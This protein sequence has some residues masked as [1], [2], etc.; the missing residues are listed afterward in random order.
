MTRPRVLI[1]SWR[2][3][4]KTAL[5][6]KTDLLTLSPN[7]TAAVSR[8]GGLPIMAAPVDEGVIPELLDVADA[9]LVSGGRDMDPALYGA[10]NTASWRVRGDYDRQDVAITRAALEQGMPVLGICR[11]AQVVNVALGGDLRQEIQERGSTVHPTYG[12]IDDGQALRHDVDIVAGTRLAAI[13]GSGTQSVNSLH[14]Q[15]IGRVADGLVGVRDGTRRGDRGGGRFRPRPRGGA[16]APGDDS[17]RAGATRCSP[18]WSVGR[19]PRWQRGH[20]R[21]RHRHDQD[22][23]CISSRCR[24]W[25]GGQIVLARAGA[26]PSASSAATRLDRRPTGSV[27]CRLAVLRARGDHRHLEPARDRRRRSIDGVPRHPRGE[28]ARR[29]SGRHRQLRSTHSPTS[30]ALR[31]ITGA[32]SA[33]LGSLAALIFG[34]MLVT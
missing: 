16:V 25:V 28:A 30:P 22:H 8:A 14:H 15:A 27:K 10:Q 32:R 11:G 3:E 7:Y 6:P 21:L 1:T 17:R 33:S 9:L 12:E 13:Y 5:G 31:G 4:L 26:G 19:G 34:V 20:D 18:T 23:R 29:G 2:R 24:W